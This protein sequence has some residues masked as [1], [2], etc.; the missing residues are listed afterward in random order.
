MAGTLAPSANSTTTTCRVVDWLRLL[1]RLGLK[2]GVMQHLGVAVL[3]EAVMLF[4]VEG[5]GTVTRL[6]A[7]MTQELQAVAVIAAAGVAQEQALQE[8]AELVGR[9]EGGEET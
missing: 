1:T 5:D 9:L 7:G 3:T 8:Q 2:Y 6:I 4:H